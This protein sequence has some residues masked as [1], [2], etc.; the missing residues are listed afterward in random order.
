MELG[1]LCLEL[2]LARQPH[3]C[4]IAW[5]L[6]T[7]ALA[8]AA[9]LWTQHVARLL[10]IDPPKGEQQ[11]QRQQVPA[12]PTRTFRLNTRRYDG[13]R[14]AAWYVRE[15]PSSLAK[16]VAQL[17]HGTEVEVKEVRLGGGR[18]QGDWLELADGSGWL[19]KEHDGAGWC[20]IDESGN[21]VP[22]RWAGQPPP[23]PRGAVRR[24][25]PA[26]RDAGDAGDATAAAAVAAPPP[27]AAA[28]AP[29][30][31]SVTAPAQN[32]AAAAP[33][34]PVPPFT[35]SKRMQMLA[36][37]AA[38]YA[39][40]FLTD[41]CWEDSPSP[42]PSAVTWRMPSSPVFRSGVRP[43]K[44]RG[45][46]KGVKPAVLAT[47][48]L[49]LALKWPERNHKVKKKKMDV[50]RVEQV[51]WSTTIWFEHEA[52]P[53]PLVADRESLYLET[54][55]YTPPPPPPSGTDG[56]R[57][58]GGGGSFTIVRKSLEKDDVPVGAGRVRGLMYVVMTFKRDPQGQ[59][60][61]QTLAM[62]FDLC[63]RVP[64]RAVD[65]FLAQQAKLFER[66]SR[67]VASE[68]GQSMIKHLE[69]RIPEDRL[70]PSHPMHGQP[71]D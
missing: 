32:E 9:L 54:C 29:T 53:V 27:P 22:D 6:F 60:T 36:A 30:A 66:L 67:F 20:Q 56:G 38:D 52:I 64:G 44:A 24:R 7:A 16:P 35:F 37:E 59:G 48:Y 68:D 42:V 31:V 21:A 65:G 1:L 51:D 5:V 33:P 15:A 3:S 8:A 4:L 61:E 49:G 26:P 19:R 55:S 40:G 28:A 23:A 14:F 2:C 39:P 50:R 25:R 12:A 62:D 45:V 43:F 41:S 10:G 17:R 18:L 69:K 47:M 63:G 58:G 11:R 71:L 57:G 34:R 13:K 46:V 70:H